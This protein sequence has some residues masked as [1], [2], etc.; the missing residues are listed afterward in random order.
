MKHILLLLLISS[1]CLCFSQQTYKLKKIE[2]QNPQN[3]NWDE[4]VL[5]TPLEIYID[6]NKNITFNDYHMT[7]M[8]LLAG[9]NYVGQY[10]NLIFLNSGLDKSDTE[11]FTDSY[12]GKLKLV[13]SKNLPQSKD[14]YVNFM[15]YPQTKNL[16]IIE[17]SNYFCM[18]HI[19]LWL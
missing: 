5:Y 2:I 10:D 14:A 15:Y 8:E 9:K 7:F 16:G 4:V 12:N 17:I 3:N 19:R 11:K 18:C 1:S 6:E 13:G